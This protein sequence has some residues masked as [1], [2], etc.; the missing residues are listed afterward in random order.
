MR[1]LIQLIGLILLLI[2]I[3]FLLGFY[4]VRQRLGTVNR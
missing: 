3:Y 4:Q 2:G 1:L